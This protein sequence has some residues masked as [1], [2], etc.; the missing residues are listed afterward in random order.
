MK[1][2]VALKQKLG[3]NDSNEATYKRINIRCRIEFKQKL[4]RDKEGK[5][6]VSNARMFTQYP[7]KLDDRIEYQGKD[8]TVISISNQTDLDGK[9]GYY[10][11][12]L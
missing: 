6:I 1:Q 11:V 5:E 8:W 7:I 4:V 12:M 10:E 9:T 3:V 2:S